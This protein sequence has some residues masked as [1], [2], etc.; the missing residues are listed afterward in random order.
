M[1]RKMLV[2]TLQHYFQTSDEILHLLKGLGARVGSFVYTYH[3]RYLPIF[4]RIE[5][6]SRPE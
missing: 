2:L 4:F 6:I 3:V 1:P 5:G